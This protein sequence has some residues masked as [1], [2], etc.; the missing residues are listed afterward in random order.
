MKY[1]SLEK[2]LNVQHPVLV[3]FSIYLCLLDFLRK[4]KTGTLTDVN[5]LN[6]ARIW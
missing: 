1:L 2:F 3:I 5:L 6:S 4:V